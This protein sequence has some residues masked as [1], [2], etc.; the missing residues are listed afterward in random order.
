MNVTEL[1]NQAADL[2]EKKGWKPAASSGECLDTAGHAIQGHRWYGLGTAYFAAIG[3]VI[4]EPDMTQTEVWA[5]NDAVC[6]DQDE[7]VN[8]LRKAAENVEAL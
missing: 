4:G 6:L 5:W 3:A 1:L 2:I 7:A 8:T